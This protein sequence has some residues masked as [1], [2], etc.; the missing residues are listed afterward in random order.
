MLEVRDLCKTYRSRDGVSVEATKHISIRFPETGMVFLLG[1]SGSGKSTL[2][3]LL[4]GLDR[5]DS[6]E[7]IVNG[8]STGDFTDAMMD[9]Y[10]NTYV[11]FVFQDYNILPEF[12]VG[13]NI[14]LAM[15]LQG[16]RASNERISEILGEVDLLDYAKRK[17][18]ELSGGQL[19]RVA[20]AR[21][22]IK[23][24]DIILADEPT[25]ALDSKTGQ[26]VFE[27]LKKL[28]KTKLVII[29]SHDRD[30]SE[31]YADRIIELADGCVVSDVEIKPVSELSGIT[32]TEF[33]PAEGISVDRDGLTVS[34]GYELTESDIDKINEFLRLQADGN[35]L[36]TDGTKVSPKKD[37]FSA[38]D[39]TRI[40]PKKKVFQLIKSKL[41]WRRSFGIGVNSMKK[42]K[43]TLF[44]T[45][46]LSVVSFTLF[47]IADV[48]Y[49]FNRV[50]CITD[51]LWE[52]GLHYL[53]IQKDVD[54]MTNITSYSDI[55]FSFSDEEIGQVCDWTGSTAIPVYNLPLG[56]K[57]LFHTKKDD[58]SVLT[59][60]DAMILPRVAMGVVEIDQSVSDALGAKLI[61][62]R[63]PE[64][65]YEVCITTQAAEMM[66]KYGDDTVRGK[67]AEELVGISYLGEN[68]RK[69][70]PV[71][72][73]GVLFLDIDTAR[74]ESLFAKDDSALSDAERIMRGM[75][76]NLC[77]TECVYGLPSFLYCAKGCVDSLR[78]GEYET[79]T[80]NTADVFV[81]LE[82]REPYRL[83][84]SGYM[85][86]RFSDT[87]RKMMM[88]DPQKTSLADDEMV[89]SAD[90]FAYTFGYDLYYETYGADP[91]SFTVAELNEYCFRCLSERQM[92]YEDR[93]TG[94]TYRIV[95]LCCGD[96]EEDY[97]ANELLVSD[98]AFAEAAENEA[99]EAEKFTRLFARMPESKRKLRSFIEK[100]SDVRDGV[101]IET[102]SGLTFVIEEVSE[103]AKVLTPVFR[104]I[105]GIL[106]AFS[107]VLFAVF[108][109][110]SVINKRQ[111]IGVLRALGA[112]SLDVYRIFLCETGVIAFVNWIISALTTRG[113]I[114]SINKN[115]DN[116][117][118]YKMKL[119][120]FG[121][122]Q[123]GLIL[124]IAVCVAIVSTY[125]PIRGIAR[126]KPIDVIRGR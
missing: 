27:T 36:I 48:F 4:G 102:N 109:A 81:K 61:A 55:D 43:V 47:G 106:A 71:T 116:D 111:E 115:L 84:D 62:G 5:Y 60:L 112:R 25:G 30:Y 7:I 34:P 107:A 42:K 1:K 29:V 32:E 23:N 39:E 19:Q 53:D 66:R 37:R 20:I 86:G 15:E 118:T 11:G 75:Y 76:R 52:S 21:A 18:N 65:P 17:P 117:Y 41:P 98:A 73:V 99:K 9:S 110:N 57:R 59:E 105:G 54:M 50:D 94:K 77:L 104:W 46:L 33:D 22:I 40:V 123:V 13:A 114:G 78:A 91:E 10:R 103:L 85:F 72:I 97:I 74:Y 88:L 58:S 44:F 108:I 121:A 95:G 16:V 35:V 126:K 100:S 51:T 67:S 83:T 12:S 64:E 80:I 92:T 96:S 6:G 31:Q 82:G 69:L 63:L 49:S 70:K 124:A 26:A 79:V 2:L 101:R 24:P 120:H 125:L 89:V 45:I 14:A 28:S 90:F 68:S 119:L 93:G 113:I 122:R 56:T 8:T 38:T 3:H 87:H